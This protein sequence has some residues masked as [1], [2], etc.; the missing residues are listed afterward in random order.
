MSERKKQIFSIGEEETSLSSMATPLPDWLPPIVKLQD[1]D[2]DSEKYLEH[3]FSIFET[4]FVRSTPSYEGQRVFYDKKDD[5]GRPGCFVHITTEEN[6]QTGEREICL[7]RCERIAWVKAIIE[8][9]DDP[10]VLVWEIEHFGKKR[11]SKR[12][13]LFLEE[14]DFLIVL[15]EIKWGHYIVT[16]VYVDHPHQKRRHQEAYK[17]YKSVNP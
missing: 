12:T 14:G 5:G 11:A 15:T 1:F 17:K 9:A 10:A 3:L 7:R 2:G 16:A 4:D 8:H 13:C 6:K